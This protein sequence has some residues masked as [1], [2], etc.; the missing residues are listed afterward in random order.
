M[1]NK[2]SDSD[3][4]A[5]G[6]DT[7]HI[8]RCT[9]SNIAWRLL[10]VTDIMVEEIGLFRQAQRHGSLICLAWNLWDMYYERISEG[11]GVAIQTIIGFVLHVG[12]SR[13]VQ[14]SSNRLAVC[15]LV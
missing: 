10:L 12:G 15:V 5:T 2:D 3:S 11:V 4:K 6:R 8:L 13:Q 1:V 9:I 14:Y 7:S